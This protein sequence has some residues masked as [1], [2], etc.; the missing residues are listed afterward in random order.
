M[1]VVWTKTPGS[2][3]IPFFEQLKSIHPDVDFEFA[4]TL[5][6]ELDSI[7]DAEIYYGWPSDEVFNKANN[8]KWIHCPGTGIDRITEAIPG[9]ASS[10]VVLTNCR[11]PHA[12]PMADHVLGMMLTITHRLNE[13]WDDQKAHRWETYKYADTFIQLTGKSMGILAL[14]D[15]GKA[16]ARRA[17]GF[18]MKVYAVDLRQVGKIPEV[19]EVWGMDK[20]DDLISKVDWFVVTAPITKETNNLIDS[21]RIGLLKKDAY[22]VII[23]RGGIVDEEALAQAL[24]NKSIA[25]AAIDAFAKEPIIDESPFW[26]MENCIISAHASAYS[27]EMAKGRLDI[28]KENL[29]RY[30]NQEDFLYVCDKRAGF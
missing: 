21:R 20:L 25:G 16:V 22:I 1:K 15:I 14:G 27:K 29:R 23:S 12:N 24:L 30:L 11:G 18:G 4:E 3:E 26:D 9:L 5:Q 17:H 28:F 7:V 8:L 10:D 2:D 13:Q 19:E 6:Q